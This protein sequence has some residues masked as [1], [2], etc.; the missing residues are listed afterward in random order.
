MGE[1]TG[2]FTNPFSHTLCHYLMVLH[3]K[4]FVLDGRTSG[5]NDEYFHK[6]ILLIGGFE[7]L[8]S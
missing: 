1:Q 8:L 3:V 7:M 6:T 2:L 4:Q 5:I